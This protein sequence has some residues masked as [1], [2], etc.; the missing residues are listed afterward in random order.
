VKAQP[1]T[2]EQ[3]TAAVLVM[4]EMI[5]FS[6]RPSIGAVNTRSPSRSTVTRLASATTSSRR[7]DV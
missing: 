2:R 5:A 3:I 4:A 6:E 1:V 7:C